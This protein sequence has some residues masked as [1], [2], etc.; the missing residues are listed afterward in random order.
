MENIAADIV[1]CGTARVKEL[2][3]N[4]LNAKTP[5][6][7]DEIK[8]MNDILDMLKDSFK[9]IQFILVFHT[10]DHNSIYFLP[11]FLNWNQF[12]NC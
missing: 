11:E 5:L 9:I 2:E 7:E 6:N 1:L 10:I 8:T 12:W 3:E 4:I